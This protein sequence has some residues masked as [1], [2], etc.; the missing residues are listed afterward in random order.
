[1]NVENLVIKAKKGDNE[2][3]FKLMALHKEQLYRTIYGYLRDEGDS[4]EGV[5]EVTYRAYIKLRKLREDKFFTTWLMKIAINYSLDELKKKNRST[6]INNLYENELERRAISSREEKVEAEVLNKVVIDEALER[7]KP[8]YK[9]IIILK[10]FEDKTSRDISQ[11]LNIPEGTVK[12]RIR[13]GLE[14]LKVLM[15]EGGENNA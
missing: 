4:L 6:A 3:F 7:L 12:T 10:Y 11:R 8:E 1:M 15:E 9:E 14:E 5:Q 2:A 13:R